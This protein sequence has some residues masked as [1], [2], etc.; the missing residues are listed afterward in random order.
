M[1]SRPSEFRL[2][3]DMVVSSDPLP[4]T[5]LPTSSVF[6]S[7]DGVRMIDCSFFLAPTVAEIASLVVVV[8]VVDCDT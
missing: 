3:K 4:I 2:R 1:A 5:G 8:V 7:S 6:V